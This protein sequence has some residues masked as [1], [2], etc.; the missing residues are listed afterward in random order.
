[1]SRDW[2]WFLA[3]MLEA[4][5]RARA[6]LGDL[7]M[8]GFAQDRKTQAAVERELAI[9]GEAAKQIPADFRVANPTLHWREMAGLRDILN[10]AYFQVDARVLWRLVREDLGS[11]IETLRNLVPVA[12]DP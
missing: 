2:R 6:H 9:L 10:H 12:E 4:A 1:M 7:D 11:D 3:D 5:E 8:E